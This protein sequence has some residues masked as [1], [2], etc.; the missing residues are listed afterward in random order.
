MR[1][2]LL[3]TERNEMSCNQ[4]LGARRAHRFMTIKRERE[5]ERE[6]PF[7]VRYET[8]F[9]AQF[10]RLLSANDASGRKREINY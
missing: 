3:A 2:R 5:T 10:A 9:E 7:D 1:R 8:R 4:A 6:T